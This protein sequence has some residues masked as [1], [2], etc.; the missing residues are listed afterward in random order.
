MDEE[1]VYVNADGCISDHPKPK[2][3]VVTSNLAVRFYVKDGWTRELLE[4]L[5]VRGKIV[6]DSHFGEPGN[7]DYYSTYRSAMFDMATLMAVI[8]HV[9]RTFNDYPDLCDEDFLLKYI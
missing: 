5:L 4:S 9:K 3:R 2:Y 6:N 8:S 7:D 1:D